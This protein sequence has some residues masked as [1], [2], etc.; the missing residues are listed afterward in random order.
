MI[1]GICSERSWPYSPEREPQTPP[2]EAYNEARRHVLHTPAK[3]DDINFL[4]Y[5]L[6]ENKPFVVGINVF[7]GF[8]DDHTRVTGM[9]PMPRNG[10]EAIGGHAVLC[11]G[12]DD[13]NGVW[14]CRNSWG[15]SWGVKG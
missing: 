5:S 13:V 12:Y 9:V 3:I 11:V 8:M 1:N 15:S 2:L 6:L 14:I 10:V 4:K 7:P